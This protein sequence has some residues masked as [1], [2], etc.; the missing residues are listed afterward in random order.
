MG[1]KTNVGFVY[2]HTKGVCGHDD[3]SLATHE[4]ILRSNSDLISHSG[5]VSSHSQP[6]A[7]QVKANLLDCFSCCGVDD[8]G[9]LVISGKPRDRCNLLFLFLCMQDINCQVGPIKTTHKRLWP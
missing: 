9:A 1:H 5:M 2:T 7:L 4:F 3:L 6:L 8:A